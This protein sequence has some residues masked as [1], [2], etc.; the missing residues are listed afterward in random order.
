MSITLA[1]N[2]PTALSIFFFLSCFLADCIHV[3]REQGVVGAH[4]TWLMRTV[5][6]CA[7]YH[8]VKTEIGSH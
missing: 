3:Q 2:Y 4:I 5:Y 8:T 7:S 1:I 6:G